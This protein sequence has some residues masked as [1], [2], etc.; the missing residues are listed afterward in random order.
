MEE[1]GFPA[2]LLASLVGL[3]KPLAS[4]GLA[5]A[6]VKGE[7]VCPPILHRKSIL[8]AITADMCLALIM[9]QAL[10]GVTH[11]LT[12]TSC[13]LMAD[14]CM[15]VAICVSQTRKSMCRDELNCLRS[16][17]YEWMSW[18]LSKGSLTFLHPR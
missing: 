7:I 11:F 15:C 12:W 4:L 9:D 10:R 2:Q 1:V 5:I 8:K 17:G 14:M 18:D 6:F 16:H 3:E 13:P